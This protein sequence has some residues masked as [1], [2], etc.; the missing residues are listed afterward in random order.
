MTV[1]VRCRAAQL[2]GLQPPAVAP[3]AAAHVLLVAPVVGLHH[4]LQTQPAVSRRPPALV[5]VS[6]HT[7]HDSNTTQLFLVFILGLFSPLT[8][9]VLFPLSTQMQNLLILLLLF[10][11]EPR[12]LR[13]GPEPAPSGPVSR[14]S[15]QLA[16]QTLE[17]AKSP[18]SC[19][20][21]APSAALNPTDD[22]SVST[23]IRRQVERLEGMFVL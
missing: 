11:S 1:V 21:L 7:Q 2:P 15:K 18:T 20:E 23:V 10:F 12:S 8:L 16:R 5:A 3:A 17:A 4:G 14:N 6:G 13:T 22:S 19:S 9:H